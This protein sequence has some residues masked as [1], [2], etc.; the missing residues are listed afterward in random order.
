MKTKNCVLYLKSEK[1][2]KICLRA[3]RL[4]LQ[5]RPKIFKKKIGTSNQPIR[6]K[7]YQKKR[8]FSSL[9]E[10]KEPMEFTWELIKQ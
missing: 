7:I 8:M 3:S 5:V 1:E 2:P 6:T 9:K 4:N 10:C